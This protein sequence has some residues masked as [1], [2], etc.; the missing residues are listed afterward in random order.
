MG[1]KKEKPGWLKKPLES[2][3]HW[4]TAVKMQ[5]PLNILTT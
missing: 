1:V 4:M 5:D 2:R 3:H